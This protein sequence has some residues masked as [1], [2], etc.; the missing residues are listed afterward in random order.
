MSVSMNMKHPR[1]SGGVGRT[2]AVGAAS[3]A[4]LA[5]LAIGAGPVFA[6]NSIRAGVGG[7]TITVNGRTISTSNLTLAQFAKLQGVPESDVNLELDRVAAGNPA[8]P[9]VE[10]LVASLTGQ[11]ALATALNQ[12][13]S[14]SGT[15]LSPASQ[16]GVPGGVVGPAPVPISSARALEEIVLD[17]GQPGASNGSNG[18]SGAAGVNGSVSG[19]AASRKRFSLRVASRS[20]RG[21]PRSRVAVHYSLSAAAKL[22]YSGS[23][24]AGG[25]RKVGSG[26]GVLMVR[27]PARHGNYLFKLKAL[28]ATEGESASTT[29]R[30]HDAPLK[31]VRK[32]R[33]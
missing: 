18:S 31:P 20:L 22:V 29:V 32:G 19:S 30:L 15:A 24:L 6:A 9:A 12:L 33:G 13:S 21:R 3:A 5:V 10:A 25:S 1:A 17:N 2:A 27:L 11:T 26:N 4:A 8:A 23:R 28:S 7:T 14:A 16:A